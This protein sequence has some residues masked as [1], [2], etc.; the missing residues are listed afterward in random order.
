MTTEQEVVA[1]ASGLSLR[2]KLEI[3]ASLIFCAIIWWVAT[4]K[5]APV[6]QWQPAKTASQVTDV[7]KTALS[8]KPVIVY[9]QAAKQNLDLPP[10][11]QADAEKHVT[12]SSKVNPDLH[13]QTVTT[14]YNDK[15][16][17]TE[18]MI[19]RDPYPWLAAEQTGEVWVGYGVKN[20][21]GRVGLLSVT[22][23]LIQVKALHFGVSGS[24]STDGS[25]FAGVGA[26]YRW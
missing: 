18:A 8:C 25:L 12:S 3:A 19:R 2:A 5:P 20:G 16:G 23:E 24:V 21:G 10:S 13:P 9:E 17:Q 14:I 1:A 22:E 7:P 4:P 26:G 11:V 6:G 15:T